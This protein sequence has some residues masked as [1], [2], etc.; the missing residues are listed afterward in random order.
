MPLI[1]DGWNLIRDRRS[2][3]DD[4]AGE[5]LDSVR[6]LIGYLEDFQRTH[7]DPII[8]VLDSSREYLGLDYRNSE[9]LSV[10]AA[11]DADAYIK[12]YVDATPE[13]QRRALRVVS[14][15]RAVYY[16]AKDAYATAVTSEEFWEKLERS[17]GQ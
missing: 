12:R 11:R 2:T 17:C 3:I 8:L 5:P 13:R 7:R 6:D 16:H 1:I 10:V 14:S 9:R 4:D 15:D